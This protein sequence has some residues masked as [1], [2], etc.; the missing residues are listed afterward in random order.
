MADR[1]I[2][3]LKRF[4][5]LDGMTRRDFMSRAVAAGVTVTAATTLWENRAEAAT[6]KKGGHAIFGSGHGETADHLGADVVS[7]AHQQQFSQ[8]LRDK[9]V[10]YGD[11]GELVPQ[12]ATEWDVSNGG[13]TWAFKIRKGVEFHNGKTL[14]PEDVVASIDIHRG[15]DSKSGAKPLAEAVD[16]MRVDGDNVVFDLKAPSADFGLYMGQYNFVVAPVID[17]K[18]DDRSG[19]GTGPYELENYEPGVR[20]AAKKFANYWTDNHGHFES[21]EFLSMKDPAARTTA[22]LTGQIHAAQ[23]ID[24]KTASRVDSTPGIRIESVSGGST[25]TMPMHANKAPF[26]NVE[27]RRAMKWAVDREELA[28][29]VFSGHASLANDHPVPPFDQFYNP[30]LPQRDYDGDKVKYHLNKAGYAGEKITLHASD[31]AFVGAVDGGVLFAETAKKAGV[32]IEVIRAPVDGYWN[33]VWTKE[34]FCYC[35]W[36]ARPTP[37]LLLSL[38][39]VTGA[40]WG[41]TFWENPTFDKLV[42]D[43]RTELDN[44]KRKELYAEIQ[45]ILH[46][47]G[48]TIVPVFQNLVHGVSDKLAHGKISGAS[49]FDFGRAFRTW[50]FKDA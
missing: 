34:P 25:I 30:D 13:Q 22:L 42:A 27:F 50:W 4:A 3:E 20:A 23:P 10:D 7:N 39:Y 28:N 38:A 6:P 43:V 37:E 41:D 21:F 35:Y 26:D 1:E 5:D 18:L 32:N 47:D 2:T 19:I 40:P 45:R 11:D 48:S 15:E 33:Q 44:A 9:L 49:P 24:F 16:T 29:K 17:G 46:H 14:V 12:L 8:S 36:N 31:A